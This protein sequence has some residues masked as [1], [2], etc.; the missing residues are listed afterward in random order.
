MAGENNTASSNNFIGYQTG[1]MNT[2]GYNNNFLGTNAGKSNTDGG[3]NTYVGNSAGSA[4][5]GS[6]NVFVGSSAGGTVTGGT[7]NFVFG[8]VSDIANPTS[9]SS[10]QKAGAIGYGTVINSS[11]KIRMGKEGDMV[12]VESWDF[13]SVSDSRFKFNIQDNDVPGINFIAG[14]RPV[15]YNFDTEQYDLFLMQNMPDS[16]ATERMKETDYEQSSSIKRTGFLAQEVEHLCNEIGYDFDGIHVPETDIDNYSL[17]IFEFRRPSRK[18]ST[19]TTGNNRRPAKADRR[20]KSVVRVQ[21]P[22]TYRNPGQAESFGREIV[23]ILN[24]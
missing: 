1:R 18:S 10:L 21:R 11:N 19:R 23:N 17:I 9:G 6:G 3:G 2:S 16:V 8:P 4:C 5:N 22:I 12:R 14:L 13:H 7:Y 15:T 24:Y 20:A